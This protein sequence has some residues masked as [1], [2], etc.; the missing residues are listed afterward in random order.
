MSGHIVR[1][2]VLGLSGF[3]IGTMLYV[4]VHNAVDWIH[5][6]G[7]LFLSRALVRLGT[8]LVLFLIADAVYRL[9]ELPLTVRVG[10]Y[11]LGLLMIFLGAVGLIWSIHDDVKET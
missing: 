5:G 1:N 3:A 6:E 2:L 10:L 9:P 11:S 7:K 4:G 8:A